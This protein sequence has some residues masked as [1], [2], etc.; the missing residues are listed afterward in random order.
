MSFVK[1]EGVEFVRDTNSMG[2][3][4]TNMTEKNEYYAKV[5]ML[6]NQKDE[7]N[8]VKS[9]MNN[10]KKDIGDI[11]SLLQQLLEKGTNG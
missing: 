1:V 3:S 11:K 7:I 10:I 2:L 6:Q 4:N 9:E 8:K 5:R